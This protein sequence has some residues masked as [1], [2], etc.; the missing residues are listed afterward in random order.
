MPGRDQLRD[1]VRRITLPRL[2]LPTGFEGAGRLFDWADGLSSEAYRALT[3]P[4]ADAA[5]L[6]SDFAAV[7]HDLMVALEH[8]DRQAI[9]N[10][11]VRALAG[12]DHY[13]DGYF[14]QQAHR[15]F[16][17]RR[18][19]RRLHRLQEEQARRERERRD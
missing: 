4:D 13:F 15:T 11:Y 8:F 2:P 10:D 5:A 19:L 1:E 3:L 6:A 14:D 12:L 16:P 7:G 17:L 18:L 9:R